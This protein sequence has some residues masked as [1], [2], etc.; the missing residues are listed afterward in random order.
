MFRDFDLRI[1]FNADQCFLQSIKSRIETFFLD[2][3]QNLNNTIL[4]IEKIQ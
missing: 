3:F 2:L 4:L 1:E